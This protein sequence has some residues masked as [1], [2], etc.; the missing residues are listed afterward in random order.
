MTTD[1]GDTDLPASPGGDAGLRPAYNRPRRYP[2][3]APSPRAADAPTEITRQNPTLAEAAQDWAAQEAA[4][5]YARPAGAAPGPAGPGAHPQPNPG[6]QPPYPYPAEGSPAGYPP[7]NGSDQPSKRGHA[8]STRV[9]LIAGAVVVVLAVVIGVVVGLSGGD[10]G[11]QAGG[12]NTRTPAAPGS[13]T[14]SGATAGTSAAGPPVAPSTPA[15]AA[16]C[17]ALGR[18]APFSLFVARPRPAERLPVSYVEPQSGTK[19]AVCVGL[20]RPAAGTGRGRLGYLAEYAQLPA[21]QYALR[22]KTLGWT[23]VP[24]LPRPT[25]RNTFRTTVT[26]VQQGTSLVVVVGDGT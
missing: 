19:T 5:E 7:A 23:L 17:V 15:V 18:T 26:L 16:S 13:T 24:T 21:T 2:V 12:P 1:D 3:Q 14:P 4:R 10:D 22:L 25:Y 8:P 20:F 9:L 6:P 11:S